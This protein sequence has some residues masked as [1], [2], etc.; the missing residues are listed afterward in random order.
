VAAVQ[1]RP[2]PW[3]VPKPSLGWGAVVH[4]LWLIAFTQSRGYIRS[5]RIVVAA[6]RLAAHAD[7]RP[8]AA[9]SISGRGQARASDRIGAN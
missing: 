2:E 3:R 9:A 6:Q 4:R 7:L 1:R 8:R 5:G